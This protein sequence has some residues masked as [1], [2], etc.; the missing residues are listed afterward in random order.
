MSPSAAG[1]DRPLTP[2]DQRPRPT[3]MSPAH[4]SADDDEL[5]ALLEASRA[6]TAGLRRAL[7]LEEAL[8]RRQDDEA[9]HLETLQ[10]DLEAAIHAMGGP[11]TESDAAVQSALIRAP[12]ASPHGAALGRQTS[13]GLLA[14]PLSLTDLKRQG[15]MVQM[16]KGRVKEL[17]D[18]LDRREE[19][20]AVL[21]EEL[22]RRRAELSQTDLVV[23]GGHR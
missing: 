11:P 13:P 23:V 19:Q 22:R 10:R 18:A 8:L 16:L 6:R 5:A 15:E 1:G 3:Q 21:S 17:E 9:R 4:H 20:M 12:G 14:G 7:G 2:Q